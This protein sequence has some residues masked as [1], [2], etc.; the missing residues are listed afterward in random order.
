[1]P[2]TPQH[3]GQAAPRRP[4]STPVTMTDY[5]EEQNNEIEALESIYPEEFESKCGVCGAGGRGAAHRP[6][7]CR[8]CHRSTSGEKSTVSHSQTRNEYLFYGAG[9]NPEISRPPCVT[10]PGGWGRREEGGDLPG[11]FTCNFTDWV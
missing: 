8:T 10:A 9:D 1:M 11:V 2:T 3:G 7:P 5:K 4:A 6:K